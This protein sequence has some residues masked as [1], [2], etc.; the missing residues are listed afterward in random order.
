MAKT[1][2]TGLGE[3]TGSGKGE[4]GNRGGKQEA[5]LPD[6]AI[7]AYTNKEWPTAQ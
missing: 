6:L 2:A 7:C 3:A 1:G 4:G 5:I